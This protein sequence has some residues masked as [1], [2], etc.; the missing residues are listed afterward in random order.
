MQYSIVLDAE[1]IDEQFSAYSPYNLKK[2]IKH[3]SEE[4]LETI[5]LKLVNELK[6]G[7]HSPVYVEIYNCKKERKIN[8][9]KIRVGDEKRKG[10]K[11]NGY[12][13]ILLIDNIHKYGYLLHIYRHSHGENDNIRDSDKN[14]LKCLVEEYYKS[15]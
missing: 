14:K 1:V 8:F 3:L 9:S 2:D 12:R 5:G 15:I 10:G 7:P 13:C 4:E 6:I 11:S